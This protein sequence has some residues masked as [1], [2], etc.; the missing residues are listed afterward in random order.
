[1]SIHR[2]L[3]DIRRQTI[4]Y[5]FDD[6]LAEQMLGGLFLLGAIAVT[7][8]T[9]IDSSYEPAV[10]VVLSLLIMTATVGSIYVVKHL[11]ETLTHART[12]Y[13]KPRETQQFPTVE[14][15]FALTIIFTAVIFSK[16][17][18]PD[19]INGAALFQG[20]IMAVSLAYV[21]YLGKLARFYMLALI[22][23]LISLLAGSIAHDM[24]VIATIAGTGLLLL[25]TGFIRLR[26]YLRSHPEQD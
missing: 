18:M 7:V 2:Q 1:M 22:P 21:G 9:M 6:G 16:L 23:L 13:V 3:E 8:Q 12:G 15:V 14:V 11:K 20:M 17:T 19:W 5:S 24:G 25:V 26:G 4:R 10:S